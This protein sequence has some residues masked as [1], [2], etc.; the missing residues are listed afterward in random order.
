M[1]KLV[2]ELKKGANRMVKVTKIR[3]RPTTM[4]ADDFDKI[5]HSLAQETRYVKNKTISLYNDWTNYQLE[6]KNK[7]GEYPKINDVHGYKMFSS[8]A[9]D[10]IKSDVKLMNTGNYTTSIKNICIAYDSHK[11]NIIG[12][13]VA[14]PNA[15]KNQ[16]IDLHNKSIYLTKVDKDYIFT[17]SLLSNKGK[18]EYGLPIG[19]ISVVCNFNGDSSVKKIVD[20]CLTGEYKIC[21]SQILQDGKKKYLNLAYNFTEVK[22]DLDKD[23]I[24]GIDVG[25][26]VPIYAAYNF[27]KYERVA[28]KDN[29]IINQKIAINNKLSYAKKTCTFTNDGHG[30]TNKM[31]VYNRYSN[32]SHNLS[33]TVNHKWS[34]YIVDQAVKNKCGTIQ[35][36]D[37]S[38]INKNNK[39]L[40]NWTY[41][42]L[43]Q[44]ITY[45][46]KEK[47]IEVVKIKPQYTSQRC[48]KCG[49]IDKNNRPTQKKFTCLKCGY[50]ANA[51][52]NAA[53]NISTREIDK[54]IDNEING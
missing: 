44:K 40:K 23:R 18:E 20:R 21:A 6:M 26:A 47:G 35:I 5:L 7:T 51:D 11:K 17:L 1:I 8:F 32:Y 52:F 30:R 49:Y 36:E 22:A 48:S 24:M 53:R 28:I 34:K 19:R 43:Q 41:Y 15:N 39:F 38:G 16:P 13:T 25:I 10:S 9:Y 54:I 33:Q 4:K 27:S 12:G 3:I 2:H 14:V 29:R 45:K 37:L 50:S 42:D 46:A 31:R